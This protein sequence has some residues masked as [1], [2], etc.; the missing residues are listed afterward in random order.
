MSYIKCTA[1]N[2]ISVVVLLRSLKPRGISL[3]PIW[4]AADR[5]AQR[6]INVLIHFILSDSAPT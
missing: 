2:S 5:I 3:T 1:L 6:M 4:P